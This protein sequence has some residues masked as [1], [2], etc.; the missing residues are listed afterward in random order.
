MHTH[1]FQGI[2]LGIFNRSGFMEYLFMGSG[3]NWYPKAEFRMLGERKAPWSL[4]CNR[5]EV[6]LQNTRLNLPRTG[7]Y[8]F[9]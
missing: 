8:S 4:I 6:E 9:L 2:F 1:I 3:L 5:T 7:K